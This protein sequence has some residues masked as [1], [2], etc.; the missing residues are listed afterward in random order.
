MMESYE[1]PPPP[2][3]LYHSF[4]ITKSRT[5]LSWSKPTYTCDYISWYP[6]TKSK[7]LMSI[8]PTP[9][10]KDNQLEQLSETFKGITWKRPC[11]YICNVFLWGNIFQLEFFLKT[12]LSKKMVFDWDVLCFECLT[13]YLEI[14]LA[15]VLS[16]RIGI[17]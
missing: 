17:G 6:H 9:P 15:L 4:F 8:A 13:G 5:R 7:P 1:Y 10:K 3:N 2:P 14:L 16:Q 12:F 11:K